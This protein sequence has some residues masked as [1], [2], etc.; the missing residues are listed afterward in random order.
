MNIPA[1]KFGVIIQGP[2]VSLA[3]QIPGNPIKHFN[4]LETIQKNY[5][6][7]TSLGGA[8]IVS[9]WD[10]QDDEERSIL[11][12]LKEARIPTITTP[13]NFPSDPDHRYKQRFGTLLGLKELEKN[14]PNNE[15]PNFLVKIRTDMLMSTN[16]WKW[17]AKAMDSSSDKLHISEMSSTMPFFMG[18]F[19][20]AGKKEVFRDFI[21]CIV[22]FGPRL[23]Y[24]TIGID[25]AMKYCH[26][27]KYGNFQSYFQKIYTTYLFIFKEKYLTDVWNK[28]ISRELKVLPKDIWT[29]T[30]WR[31]HPMSFFVSPDK[32]KYDTLP[33]TIKKSSI[34]EKWLKWNTLMGNYEI[35]FGKRKA[36]PL[37]IKIYGVI[38]R[39]K[40]QLKRGANSVK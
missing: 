17:I 16:F 21:E 28:F 7:I 24:P 31:G 20:Y 34:K 18:D 37:T 8:V 26:H 32:F 22:G 5:Q 19:I 30:I 29:E 23:L 10:P 6:I 35:C 13:N 25:D 2:L 11:K 40:G 15:L 3:G 1:T 39:L 27:K 4:N 33:F 9:T 12:G 14:R 38:K 36:L